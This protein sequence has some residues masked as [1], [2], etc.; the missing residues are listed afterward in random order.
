M[1]R[2]LVIDDDPE[3]RAV[4]EQTLQSAGHQVMLVSDGRQGLAQ[5]AITPADLVITDLYMP[6]KDG[7][8]TIIE[9]RQRFPKVVII[10]MSGR[11]AASTML[12]IAQQLGAIEVLLKP[13]VS[14]EL[15]RAVDNALRDR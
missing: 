11:T 13:F 3:M 4:L 1:P 2:I 14:G 7:L 10:A 6:N 12:S 9:L 15:L 8:E 5:I